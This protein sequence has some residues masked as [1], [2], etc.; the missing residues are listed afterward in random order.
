M[1]KGVDFL[2]FLAWE[3]GGGGTELGLVWYLLGLRCPRNM[4][5]ELPRRQLNVCCLEVS[6][7]VPIDNRLEGE[8]LGQSH[9]T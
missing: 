4:E 6:R 5:V 1:G 9:H 7:K 2:G 3:M 8:C